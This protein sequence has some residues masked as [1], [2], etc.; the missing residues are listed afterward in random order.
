MKRSRAVFA[1]VLL[2]AACKT[3]GPR[4][5]PAAGPGGD[6]LRRYIGE[7]RVLRHR[8]DQKQITATAAKPLTGECDMVV[9]VRSAA[10]QKRGALL[11]L[12]TIGRPSVGGREPSCRGVQPGVQLV[13]ADVTA[14]SS[15][16]ASR[17]DAVLQTP[18]AYLR[19]KGVAFDR[20]ESGAPKEIASPDVLA[21][22]VEAG[23]GRKVTAWPKVLLSVSPLFH[24]PSG[25]VRQESEV[26][27]EAVVGTD[28]RV[29]DPRLKTALSPAHQDVVLGALSRWRYEPAHTASAPVAARISSRMAL[30]IY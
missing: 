29:H 22:A 26:E 12:D 21:P 11:G 30:R 16:L 18:D 4:T 15:D 7:V 8:A 27:F 6:P 20:A 17:I 28:G 24:D 3:A 2:S 13:V 23:L 25:R 10:F 14:A 9:R 19:A 5:A 1:V